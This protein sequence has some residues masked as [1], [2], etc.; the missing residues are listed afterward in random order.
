MKPALPRA[1]WTLWCGTPNR[2]GPATSKRFMWM[3]ERWPGAARRAGDGVFCASGG[4]WP[5]T[6]VLKM[7]TVPGHAWCT[8]CSDTLE[9]ADRLA[10]CPLCGSGQ[11]MVTGGD[12]L[13]VRELEVD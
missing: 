5:K 12:V 6:P 3:W 11:L 10:G 7:H 2:P 4:R 9:V 1:W 13:K 8:A